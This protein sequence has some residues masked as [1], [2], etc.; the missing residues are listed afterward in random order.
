[1]CGSEGKC[2]KVQREDEDYWN[3]AKKINWTFKELFVKNETNEMI[4]NGLKWV[5]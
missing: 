4:K 1:M 5:R 3:W 2:K